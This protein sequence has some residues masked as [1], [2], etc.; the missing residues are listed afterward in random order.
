MIT[1]VLRIEFLLFLSSAFLLFVHV[2]LVMVFRHESCI[3][4]G[5][6][7]EPMLIG[8]RIYPETRLP[9]MRVSRFV[10]DHVKLTP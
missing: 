7:H 9:V 8:C 4:P 2:S 10:S 5:I 1:A 3:R 6:R